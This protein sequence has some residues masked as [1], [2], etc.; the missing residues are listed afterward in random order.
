MYNESGVLVDYNGASPVSQD[1]VLDSG[2]FASGQQ[3]PA[4][5]G[6]CLAIGMDGSN[7]V[8]LFQISCGTQLPYI[9]SEE[10]PSKYKTWLYQVSTY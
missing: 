1:P 10:V 3:A 4:G 6:T 5:S 2:N 9:C 7:G 8:R